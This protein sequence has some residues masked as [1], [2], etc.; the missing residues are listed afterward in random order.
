MPECDLKPKF[1]MQHHNL[2]VRQSQLSATLS[3]KIRQIKCM[4]TNLELDITNLE[5]YGINMNDSLT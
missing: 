2:Q 3:T 4:L 1:R 5:W